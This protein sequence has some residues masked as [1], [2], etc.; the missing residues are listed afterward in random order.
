MVRVE[1][2]DTCGVRGLANV[3]W[4]ET[5]ALVCAGSGNKVRLVNPVFTLEYS[6]RTTLQYRQNIG[7]P[8]RISEYC[9]MNGSP[10]QDYNNKY[11]IHPTENV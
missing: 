10:L 6:S 5:R 7:I 3:E 4:H 11:G 9:A 8:R 1:K 2:Y